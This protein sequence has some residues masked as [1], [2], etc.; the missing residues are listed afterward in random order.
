MTFA[1]FHFH[2][3]DRES[4][5]DVPWKND[6]LCR[7]LVIGEQ[8]EINDHLLPAMCSVLSL[9]LYVF[10]HYLIFIMIL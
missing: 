4:K 3:S 1:F 8:K 10:S 5:E 6:S 2:F 9:V 7:G